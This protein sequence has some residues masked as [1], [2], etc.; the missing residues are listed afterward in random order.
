MSSPP[1]ITALP[2]LAIAACALLPACG[3]GG[4]S[5]E[6]VVTGNP[7]EFVTSFGDAGIAALSGGPFEGASASAR[8]VSASAGSGAIRAAGRVSSRAAFARLL[9]NG[10]PD[11]AF[12]GTGSIVDSADLEP[13]PI[14]LEG[15][16]AIPRSDTTEMLV[17]SVSTPCLTGPS[18]ATS[19]GMP[20]VYVMV[21]AVNSA[22]LPVPAYGTAGVATLA[23]LDPW[24]ALA[25]PSGAVL[26][27]GRSHAGIGAVMRARLAR[28]LPSGLADDAFAANAAAAIDCPGLDPLS[29]VGAA[30]TRR[31]DGMLLLAQTFETSS[32]Q[33]SS[34]TCLTRLQADGTIDASF[35]AGGHA[36]LGWEFLWDHNEPVA[37]FALAN[38]GSALFLQKRRAIE[39]RNDY[40]YM[41]ATT[42][43]SGTLDETRFDRGITGPTDL[44][45]ARLTAV[46]RQAD[47]KFLLAGY[48]SIGGNP[49][50]YLAG[51]V[52]RFDDSQ[53][54][55]GRILPEGGADLSFGPLGT[56]YAPLLSSG[57]RL[58]PRYL[59]IAPDRGIL[60]AG[61]AGAAG[62]VNESETTRFAIAKLAGDAAAA[63]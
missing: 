26:V 27:L 35:G 56:G 34:R 60:V 33:G 57:R 23:N 62:P 3:G 13:L 47:G 53:P 16:L 40:Y 29:V 17:E 41:I 52:D 12:A 10:A 59:H 38:G 43:A 36:V 61:F 50:A 32:V 4:G 8:F 44:H 14:V 28:L 2:A 46:A 42:T 45:V 58:A 15:L 5:A 11:T 24:Q 7:G 22:G 18:C 48:P 49:P 1:F 51:R 63:P 21:R 19:G 30:M 6:P 55:V 20:S 39:G 54:R 31:S 25:E 37:I 9:A